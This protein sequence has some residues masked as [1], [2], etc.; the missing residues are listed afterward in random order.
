MRRMVMEETCRVGVGEGEGVGE[1]L[2]GGD[3]AEVEDA[4]GD[5]APVM[6]RVPVPM[7]KPSA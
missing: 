7:P 4:V 3:L 5:Q 1:G 6:T 2:A